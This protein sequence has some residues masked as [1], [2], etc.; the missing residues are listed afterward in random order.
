MEGWL[1]AQQNSTVSVLQRVREGVRG[2]PKHS[3]ECLEASAPR[4]TSNGVASWTNIEL[5]QTMNSWNNSLSRVFVEDVDASETGTRVTS[6]FGLELFDGSRPDSVYASKH[7]C[8]CLGLLLTTSLTLCNTEL[9]LFCWANISLPWALFCSSGW[10]CST[11]NP[12]KSTGLESSRRVGVPS[13][14]LSF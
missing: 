4:E 5:L 13:F 3:Q 10:V 1:F 6:R 11:P 14:F 8:G 2:K 7:S 12:I 9:A